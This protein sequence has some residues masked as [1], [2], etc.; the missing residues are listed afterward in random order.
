MTMRAQAALASAAFAAV[1]QYNHY[2]PA[3]AVGPNG[4]IVEM[5]RHQ[6]GCL[7]RPA[8]CKGQAKDVHEPTE[9]YFIIQA[10]S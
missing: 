2:S 7:R 3:R 8:F 5:L 1:R 10:M 6:G 4:D 9:T